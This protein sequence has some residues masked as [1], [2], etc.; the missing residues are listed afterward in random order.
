MIMGKKITLF[1]VLFVFLASPAAYAQGQ[2]AATT[3]TEPS[4]SGLAL[5]NEGAGGSSS[6]LPIPRFVS[7]AD[8]ETFVRTGPALRYPIKWT[9]KRQYMPVEVIQE[10][11]T[12]RKIRDIDG[13]TGWIYHS[14]LSGNRS[15]VVKGEANLAVRKEPQPESKIIAY[16][17]PQVVAAVVACHGAWCEVESQGYDGWAE[18]KFLWGIYDTEDFD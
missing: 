3:A 14:L 16:L 12:W 10:Y 7:L 5:D 18:R 15:V 8:P 4:E 9:Y 6:G 17:E 11:D 1:A 2:G 13:D